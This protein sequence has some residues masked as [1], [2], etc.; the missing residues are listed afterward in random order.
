[1]RTVVKENP[2]WSFGRTVKTCSWFFCTHWADSQI[3]A[4]HSSARPLRGFITTNEAESATLVTAL[5]P[6]TQSKH[7]PSSAASHLIMLMYVKPVDV[8][9]SNT[10]LSEYQKMLTESSL[11]QSQRSSLLLQATC[12]KVTFNKF[13]QHHMK[14]HLTGYST[15]DIYRIL[16]KHC[17]HQSHVSDGHSGALTYCGALRTSLHVEMLVFRSCI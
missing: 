4:Q 10:L 7:T 6:N 2:D 17:V 12:P 9:Y 16:H 15:P 1:M 5:P 8:N 14:S 3:C 13:H 11:Q